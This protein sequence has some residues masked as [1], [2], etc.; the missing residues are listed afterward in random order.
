MS[1]KVNCYAPL[2]RISRRYS[3][4]PPTYWARHFAC[5]LD[6]FEIMT[7]AFQHGQITTEGGAMCSDSNML[8]FPVMKKALCELM[9]QELRPGERQAPCLA[10]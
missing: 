9:S 5:A 6:L 8:L 3:G 4:A 10:N 2:A 7:A 1:P